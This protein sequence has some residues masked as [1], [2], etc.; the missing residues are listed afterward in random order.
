MAMLITLSQ[1]SSRLM[2][3]SSPRWVSRSSLRMRAFSAVKRL[4][5]C[6]CSGVSMSEAWSLRLLCSSVSFA[7]VCCSSDC[8]SQRLARKRSSAWRL[9]ASTRSKGRE[10]VARPRML[11]KALLP[12]KLSSTLATKSAVVGEGLR[13]A[14]AEQ[15]ARLHPHV[16][17]QQVGVGDDDDVGGH[18]GLG[19]VRDRRARGGLLV[20][21]A[22]L[23]DRPKTR[24]R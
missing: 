24:G 14:L 3:T 12:L 21:A 2:S 22:R 5:S 8:S 1:V 16:I 9:S 10:K 20:G 19:Q 23:A 13:N 6:S 11:I 18:R 15:L 17:H 7:S 4:S